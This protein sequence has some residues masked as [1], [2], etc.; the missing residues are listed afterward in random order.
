MTRLKLSPIAVAIMSLSYS[1]I[2]D[3]TQEKSIER[4]SVYGQQNQ[5]I[6][7]SGT[8]TKSNMDLIE[9]PA[10]LVV[11]DKALIEQQGKTDLQQVI[12]NISGLNQAG[13]NYGIGDNLVIRGL[14]VNYTYDGMYAGADL[15]NSFNP[16]RSMTNVESIEVLKGPATGLYGIGSAGGVI[17]LVEKKPQFESAAQVRASLGSWNSQQ[18]MFD[19]TGP[20]A[21]NLAYR[22]V[23]NH[24]SSDGYRDLGS[25]RTELFST[26]LFENAK[27][28]SFTLTT[29][30][31]DD[32]IQIDSVGHPVRILNH[33]SI[34][35]DAQDWT[36]LVND[37]GKGIQL[38]DEQRQQLANSIVSTDGLHPYDIDEVNL[39]S[40][41]A[42]PNKGE[43]LRVKLKS[44]WQIDATTKLTQQIQFRDYESQFVRQTGAYNY[45]YWNR[46]GTINANP[47]APLVID[48]VLY[49][50]AARR[51]EYRRQYSEEQTLQYFADLQMTWS[52][53]GIEG[54]HL[55]SVNYED[56]DM[57]VK[58]WSIYDADGSK[59]E[60]VLPYILD[61]RNPNWPTGKFDDYS[62]SFRSHY[63]KTATATGISLQEVVYFNDQLTARVGTAFT[64]LKQ[65][66]QHLGT[67]RAPGV[68]EEADTDDQGLTYN[69]G[70]NY[71]VIPEVALF[72]NVAKGRTAYSI[73]GSLSTTSDN[74]P[75][76]ESESFDLG[77]R[78]TAFDEEL[79]GSVVFFDT[80]RTNLRYTNELYNNDP[81]SPEYNVDVPQYFYDDEDKTTG[82]EVDI[83]L[84]INQALS[85]NANMT[86]QDAELIKNANRGS[87]NP[88]S[89]PVKGVP[90]KFASVWG[91][92]RQSMFNLPGEV[93]ASLGMTYEDE[94]SVD[95]IYFGLPTA[96][97]GSY[98]IWNAALGYKAEKWQVN[99]NINN[100]FDKT[101]YSKAMFLG[102]LPGEGR[103]AKL[104]FN[105]NF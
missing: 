32:S 35:G 79:L 26:F 30:Y 20:L 27:N 7:S 100:L 48:D 85:M 91:H 67:D 16:T 49:P 8:A 14:G 41:L 83:N 36:A 76:S 11:I 64:T 96:T 60:N 59:A 46:R 65:K 87:N 51:Q 25:E 17:N 40:P 18:I 88:V 15:G 56:R 44:D 97:V 34:T 19:I 99:L 38:T 84:D 68:G 3:T 105:Y 74:R 55:I 12:N 53:S 28:H 58:S 31:V 66:Y 69:V 75:D 103:N 77:V 71:R 43:D 21:K 37:P 93:T 6:L 22:F 45:V 50:Y 101:Y 98:N 72:A 54:E 1:A 33:D 5:L 57:H 94:R 29:A 2:S 80:R 63:D 62:P 90:K 61:I 13:N 102:G 47:R 95:S 4:I 92:Y 10:A 81:T 39:I 52:T 86:Y 42:T 73:L 24:E 23:G 104:T 9:I 78:F 70:I 82:V 89:G